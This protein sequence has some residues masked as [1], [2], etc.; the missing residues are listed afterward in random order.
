MATMLYEEGAEKQ[1]K[2]LAE[3]HTALGTEGRVILSKEML[4]V[5]ARR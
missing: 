2:T 1:G 5:V 4:A 3:M